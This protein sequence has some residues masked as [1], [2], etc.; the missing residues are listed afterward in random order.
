MT[1]HTLRAIA[2][3]VLACCLGGC[4]VGSL[5]VLRSSPPP[6]DHRP[7]TL[8][9][10]NAGTCTWTEVLARR[11]HEK[12]GFPLSKPLLPGETTELV[13]PSDTWNEIEAS[14]PGD[15]LQ[16][17]FDVDVAPG[18]RVVLTLDG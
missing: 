4:G 16:T 5:D 17:F 11:P 1:Y 2:G 7:G 12:T 8:V 10:V 3:L 18:G 15:C 9:L 6:I 13:V 14:G